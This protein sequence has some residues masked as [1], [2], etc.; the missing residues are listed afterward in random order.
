MA[1]IN[2]HNA[3]NAGGS[4]YLKAN[5]FADYSPEEY[6]KLLGYKPSLKN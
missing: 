4:F 6:K 1:L 5:K 2:N 3:N